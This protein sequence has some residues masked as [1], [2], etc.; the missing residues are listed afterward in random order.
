M[1]KLFLLIFFLS[2]TGC[3]ITPNNNLNAAHLN[4][5]LGIMYCDNHQYALAKEK[6]LLALK[7]TPND[8]LVI[9]SFAY[10]L[11]RTHNK[12]LANKFYL[13]ALTLA[14][15]QG[16]T[17]NNYAIFLCHQKLYRKAIHHFMI[18]A[19]NIYY[20]NSSQ[21]HQN[22]LLCYKKITNKKLKIELE[23]KYHFLGLT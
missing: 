14:P 7:L 5:R 11:F 18:A 1:L 19:H 15:N 21:A 22:A 23:A 13:K 2:L 17:H 16:A 8:P 9:D 4:A 3:N 6:L 10:F 20:L 12:N